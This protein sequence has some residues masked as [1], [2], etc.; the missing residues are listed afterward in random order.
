MGCGANGVWHEDRG[1]PMPD[2]MLMLGDDIA[3]RRSE[4]L[5]VSRPLGWLTE[6]VRSLSVFSSLD[7]RSRF[8]VLGLVSIRASS[9][10][11]LLGIVIEKVFLSMMPRGDFIVVESISNATE[12]FAEWLGENN[13]NKNK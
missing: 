2:R 7:L 1:V 3:S 10:D 13:K 8:R 4:L 5:T 9:K 11:I 12:Y 6:I